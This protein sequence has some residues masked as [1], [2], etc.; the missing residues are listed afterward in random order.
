MT[1]VWIEA[2]D[3]HGQPIHLKKCECGALNAPKNKT[4]YWCGNGL[5]ETKEEKNRN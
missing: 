2:R 3:E 1:Y 4:C 5:Y